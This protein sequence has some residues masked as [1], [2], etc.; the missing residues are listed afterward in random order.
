MEFENFG[1]LF[2]WNRCLMEDD[3]NDGQH[4]TIKA[5][6]KINNNEFAH[7]FKAGEA[8]NGAHKL[9]VEEK[10]KMKFSEFGGNEMELKWKNNGSFSY[11]Y[12]NNGLQVSDISDF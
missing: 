6:N 10:C 4:L 3:W 2:K 11:E 12:E 8:K 5:K 1:D 7:T 9:S